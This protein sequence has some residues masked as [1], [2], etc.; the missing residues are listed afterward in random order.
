MK[1]LAAFFLV[2]MVIVACSPQKTI[3]VSGFPLEKGTTWVY[4]YEGY[5]ASPSDPQ[6]LIRA[7]YQLTE[8]IVDTQ[9]VSENFVAHV[10][11]E[12]KLIQADTGWMQD[13]TS[14]QNEFWYVRNGQKLFQSNMPLDTSNIKTE[15]LILDYEFPLTLKGN[16]CLLSPSGK[17]STPQ[18]NAGC[19]FVGKR[20]VTDRGRYETPAGN[21]ENCYDLVD[22]FNGG[23]I[24]QKLC[25]GVGIVFMKFDHSGSRF[26]FEKTLTSYSKGTP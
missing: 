13:F 23:N 10:K 25:D 19:D 9:T 1:H 7:T 11:R 4:S 24:Y 8:T 15:E 17:G 26:G 18:D 12:R 21:F 3:E 20:A 16:W 6:R 5:D 22:Y 14:E 2:G